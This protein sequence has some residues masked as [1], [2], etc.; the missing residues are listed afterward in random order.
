MM[1]LYSR[2]TVSLARLTQDKIA[3]THSFFRKTAVEIV[4]RS[5]RAAFLGPYPRRLPFDD[6]HERHASFA[7]FSWI[8][9]RNAQ[10]RLFFSL[11]SIFDPP[12]G[13]TC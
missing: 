5:P 1:L 11:Q 6:E 10:T 12:G 3:E 9:G 8:D 7:N 2:R 4:C 13:R